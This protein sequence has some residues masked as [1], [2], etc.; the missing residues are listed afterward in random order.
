MTRYLLEVIPRERRGRGRWWR[1]CRAGYTDD[2]AEA[3]VYLHPNASM[4]DGTHPT[5]RA[6]PVEDV[7][8][9]LYREIDR[10]QTEIDRLRFGGV[11]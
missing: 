4:I 3:G 11:L 10:L 7:I 2:I 1:E 5:T 6:R 9:D 8:A